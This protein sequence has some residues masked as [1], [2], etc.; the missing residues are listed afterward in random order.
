MPKHFS[1]LVTTGSLAVVMLTVLGIEQ[2]RGLPILFLS[3]AIVWLEKRQ[4][5]SQLFWSLILGIVIATTYIFSFTLGVALILGCLE[6]FRLVRTS[7]A[8]QTTALLCAS[9]AGSLVVG[10][11]GKVE[12]SLLAVMASSLSIVVLIVVSK[13]SSA[14]HTKRAHL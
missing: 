10:I 6:L 3:L 7:L 2:V 1:Y 13:L 9:V 12:F 11:I 14:Q 4:T 5:T 8:S